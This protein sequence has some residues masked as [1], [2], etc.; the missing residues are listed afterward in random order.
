MQRA[1]RAHARR[2]DAEGAARARERA[3]GPPRRV[4]ST[5]AAGGIGTVFVLGAG[6]AGR[7]LA[8]ALV[9][10]GVDVVGLHGRHADL[11]ALPPVTAGPLPEALGAASIV[12][13]TVRDAQLGDALRELAAAGLAAG[14]VVLHASGAT[15][16]AEASAAASAGSRCR[17]DASARAARE[18][19]TRRGDPA[20]RV[21][22]SR[23][24]PD[25]PLPP[26]P[27]WPNGSGRMP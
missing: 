27:R 4:S 11:A 13:V 20:R 1:V 14:A 21:D 2:E 8:R 12:L 25:R 19:G 26:A 22:R 15:D 5:A 18:P 3:A 17:H 24:R 9:V 6:R 16:P 23:R 7:S 10:A